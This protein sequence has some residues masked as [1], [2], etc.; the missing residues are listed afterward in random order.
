MTSQPDRATWLTQ[1][2]RGLGASDIPII[3]E[4]T[5]WGTPW[6]IWITKTVQDA[7]DIEP[8]EAM[9][10]GLLLEDAIL[11]EWAKREHIHI[12]ERQPHLQH[13]VHDWMLATP[14]AIAET[15]ERRAVVEIKTIGMGADDA[16]AGGDEVP[17]YVILQVQWQMMVAGVDRA[18]V[19]VFNMVRRQL[20]THMLL[21]DPELQEF[22]LERMG[23]WWETH[24]VGGVPPVV[25]GDDNALLASLWPTSREEVVEVD[26]AL[27]EELRSARAA[28]K[29]A[30]VR[31][32]ELEARL[33][34]VLGD[35]DTAVVG[36]VVV[37]TWKTQSRS[38]Y[39]VDDGTMRVLR[40]K[41]SK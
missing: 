25:S 28:T 15:E 31:Q 24:V 18:F 23:V 29:M 39:T 34:S 35:A 41:E 4:T 37:A 13:P 2:R 32:D 40:V 26:G 6:Q 10:W 8:T 27:I 21:A 33:K 30:K 1:R 38:G 5:P 22:L 3:L 7:P 9:Q 16:W 20:Q 19:V 36:D 11:T 14:D 12:V 17:R